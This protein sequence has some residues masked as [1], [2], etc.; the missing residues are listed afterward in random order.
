MKRA[1]ELARP[2]DLSSA[3]AAK[4]SR[5]TVRNE[6]GFVSVRARYELTLFK[7]MCRRCGGRDGGSWNGQRR[8][9]RQPRNDTMR[10]KPTRPTASTHLCV[11]IK[12]RDDLPILVVRYFSL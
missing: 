12:V 11:F 5:N 3:R 8:R 9:R 4:E 1:G 10:A 6:T 2:W 7:M